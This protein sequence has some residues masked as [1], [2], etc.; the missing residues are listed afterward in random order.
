M[1]VMIIARHHRNFSAVALLRIV[2]VLFTVQSRV[3]IGTNVIELRVGDTSFIACEIDLRNDK[4]SMHWKSDSGDVYGSLSALDASLQRQGKKMLCGSNGGI[5]DEAQKPLGLYVE[6]GILLRRLNVRR[7]G[8][9]NFYMQPNGVFVVYVD[10]AEI[11]TT[12]EYEAKP[13]AERRLIKFANQSGPVL[14]HDGEV[15]PQFVPGSANATTRNAVCVRSPVSVALV[16][17][18]DPVNL[19]AFALAL[20]EAFGCQSALYLDGTLSKFFPS[21]R[22]SL[23]RPLGP[24]F[25]VTAP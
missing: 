7:R 25:A 19:Y 2:L 22:L 6:N 20:K 15:N 17:A 11:V 1:S 8:Y 18:L 10:R 21:S 16:V 13:D 12:D 4:L 24:L 5:F 14:V 9:G 23:E 3:A